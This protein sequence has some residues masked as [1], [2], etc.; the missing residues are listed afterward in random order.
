MRFKQETKLEGYI[1]S[2][3][4]EIKNYFKNNKIIL[5]WL[6]NQK[7]DRRFIC[8]Y[9][10]IDIPI[11][12][13]KKYSYLLKSF[14]NSNFELPIKFFPPSKKYLKLHKPEIIQSI[15]DKCFI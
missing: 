5:E 1:L 15:L 10:C 11:N 12:N 14:K 6:L 7:K 2:D 13:E 4:K 8:M 9:V 3:Y